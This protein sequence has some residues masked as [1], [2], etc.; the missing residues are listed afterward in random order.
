M[1][2][3]GKLGRSVRFRILNVRGFIIE[4]LYCFFDTQVFV[5]RELNIFYLSFSRHVL[6]SFRRDRAR[7]SRRALTIFLANVV[8]TTFG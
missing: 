4:Y 8:T 3:W 1:K 5:P 6:E 2:S 7:I